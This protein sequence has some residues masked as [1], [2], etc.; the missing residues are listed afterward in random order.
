VPDQG[1]GQRRDAER[2]QHRHQ[3]LDRRH[4]GAEL[5][6]QAHQGTAER[7]H[8]EVEGGRLQDQADADREDRVSADHRRGAE[9]RLSGDDLGEPGDPLGRGHLGTFGLLD[10]VEERRG[11]VEA[12]GSTELLGLLDH[13]LAGRTARDDEEGRQH[14][15]PRL[16]RAVGGGDAA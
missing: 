9:P 3:H 4:P 1:D 8:A 12:E 11:L 5:L 15:D 6:L 2:R 13:R 16:F 10:Q 7:R 14:H